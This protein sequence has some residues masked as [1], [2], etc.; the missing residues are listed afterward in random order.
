MRSCAT[1]G[2]GVMYIPD[3][4][5]HKKCKPVSYKDLVSEENAIKTL[6]TAADVKD[7]DTKSPKKELKAA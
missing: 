4:I 1:A 6:K 7:K 3:E 5:E 2:G